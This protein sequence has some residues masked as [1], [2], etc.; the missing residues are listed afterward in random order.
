MVRLYDVVLLFNQKS[1]FMGSSKRELRE[2]FLKVGLPSKSMFVT[3]IGDYYK[4][5]GVEKFSSK[6]SRQEVVDVGSVE[7]VGDELDPSLVGSLVYYHKGTSDSINL[8]GIGI[9]DLVTFSSVLV[10][11]GDQSINNY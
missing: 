11:R 4:S 8:R 3:P 1:I 10:V 7:F 9:Y 5:A 2:K 6:I